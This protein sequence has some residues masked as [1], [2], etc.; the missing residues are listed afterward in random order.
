MPVN[1]GQAWL[2]FVHVNEPLLISSEVPASD[3]DRGLV[4]VSEVK[5]HDRRPLARWKRVDEVDVLQ[6]VDVLRRII[7]PLAETHP[8]VNQRRSGP[9]RET[10]QGIKLSHESGSLPGPRP[11]PIGTPSRTKFL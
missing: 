6:V 10:D 1:E 2:M 5:E 11:A 3:S 8:V 7:D 9:P 4:A